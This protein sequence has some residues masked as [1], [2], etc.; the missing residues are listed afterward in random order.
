MWEDYSGSRMSDIVGVDSFPKYS[1]IRSQRGHKGV[2][3]KERSIIPL[4]LVCENFVCSV[5]YKAQFSLFAIHQLITSRC[6]SSLRKQLHHP[7]PIS[8]FRGK[9]SVPNRPVRP[10]SGEDGTDYGSWSVFLEMLG[11]T[12]GDYSPSI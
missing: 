10:S 2:I 1:R 9:I 12:G 6:R 7:G 3:Q 8:Q 11:L 4:P 5:T